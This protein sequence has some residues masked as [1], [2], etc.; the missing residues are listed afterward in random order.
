MKMV[1][2]SSRVPVL[3]FMNNDICANPLSG[4]SSKQLNLQSFKSLIGF[5]VVFQLVRSGDQII[6]ALDSPY[7]KC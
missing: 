7:L 4:E 6:T 3:D 2:G 1:K 5:L